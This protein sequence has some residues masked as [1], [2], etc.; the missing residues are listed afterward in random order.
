MW[1]ADGDDAMSIRNYEQVKLAVNIFLK[2]L[3][4]QNPGAIGQNLL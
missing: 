3:L 2:N 1:E 4:Q